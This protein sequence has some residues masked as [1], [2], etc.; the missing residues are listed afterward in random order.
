M[1]HLN[2]LAACPKGRAVNKNLYHWHRGPA[3]TPLKNSNVRLSSA[4]IFILTVLIGTVAIADT[5]P[6]TIKKSAFPQYVHATAESTLDSLQTDEKYPAAI[7]SLQALFDQ[8]ILYSPPDRLDCIREADFALRLARQ[9][10]NVPVATR[11]ELLPYLRKHENLANTLVFLIRTDQ[12]RAPAVYSLLNQLREKRGEQLENYAGLTSSICV[13]QHKPFSVHINENAVKSADPIDIFDYYV[14]NESR[15]FFGI[16][17]VP[18]ELLVYVV[19]TTASISD[20]DWALNKYAGNSNVGRLFFD[21][22]YDYEYLKRGSDKKVTV[23]GYNLPNILKFGGICADQA[24]FATSVGKAIGVPT[25]YDTGVSAEAA[26][27]WVGFLQYN[28]KAGQ[29]NF[30]SGRYEDYQG[31][32]GSVMDP[33]SRQNVPDS[34]VS[35]LSEIIG[36]RATDRQTAIALTD[37]AERLGEINKKNVDVTAPPVDQVVKGTFSN[38][39]RST[40]AAAQLGL[41]ESALQKSVACAP[42]WFAVRDLAVDKKLTLADKQHWSDLLLKLGA[43]K[44]PDFTLTVLMPMVQTIEDAPQQDTLLT[45]MLPLF[46]SRMD[47]S[48]SILMAQAHLWEQQN[49]PNRAGSIVHASGSALHEQRTVC[50][51]CVKRRGKAAQ[52]HQSR[53]ASARALRPGVE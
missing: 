45:R 29:W 48:A 40:D 38:K 20:M 25:A 21:I 28:G 51:S 18:A 33:I 39:P 31:V 34:Y 2:F 52:E 35:L 26:H 32:R 50:G 49:Q 24:Y 17:N 53:R 6:A 43:Q 14:K 30:N 22:K 9:L 41:I 12:E 47:L 8:T 3:G 44:Y 1:R 36:T 10:K 7:A 4:S 19:D 16:R 23:A 46:A 42:A 13:V 15:M 37:A 5:P 11:S 27:A